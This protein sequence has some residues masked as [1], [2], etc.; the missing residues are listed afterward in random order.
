MF[1][2]LYDKF[3][4]DSMYQILSELVRFCRRYNK[5]IMVCFWFTMHMY[6][7]AQWISSWIQAKNLRRR[8][9]KENCMSTKTPKNSLRIY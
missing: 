6:I 2:F 7:N 8:T 4:Q 5:S 9:Q 1:T 3:T